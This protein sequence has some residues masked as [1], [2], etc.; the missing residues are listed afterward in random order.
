MPPLT[1]LLKLLIQWHMCLHICIAS[2]LFEDPPQSYWGFLTMNTER[3]VWMGW[4]LWVG[5]Y[6]SDCRDY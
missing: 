4:I 2:E 6:P 5:S 1:T 3:T